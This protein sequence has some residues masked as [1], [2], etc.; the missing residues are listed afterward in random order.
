M[1]QT[2]RQPTSIGPYQLEAELGIGKTGTVYRAV[3]VGL[4]QPRALKV[5]HQHLTADQA[6]HARFEQW[7]RAQEQLAHP[8]V[9]RLLDGGEE[10]DL[11]Y[12]AFELLDHPLR[13]ELRRGSHQL[14]PLETAV[15]L[16]RQAADALVFAHA[17]GQ[18][19][20]NLKPENLLLTADGATL[21]V[22]DI[23]VVQVF[24]SSGATGDP[25][26][27]GT[28]AY[29]AP[30][31]LQGRLA[32]AGTDVFALGVILYE[33]TT[34]FL[35]FGRGLDEVIKRQRKEL[36][37]MRRLRPEVSPELEAIVLRCLQP[38]IKDRYVNVLELTEA[39][40]K[41]GTVSV[42]PEG[43]QERAA[44]DAH[45]IGMPCIIVK[46]LPGA[47]PV[48]L[49]GDM[50]VVGH[51]P[52][53]DLVLADPVISER[54][55][56]MFW[57]GDEARVRDVGVTGVTRISGRPLRHNTAMA[58]HSG[59]VLE[60]GS[61]RLELLLPIEEP[62]LEHSLV[63]AT[64]AMASPPPEVYVS[65]AVPSQVTVTPGVLCE[66]PLK[67]TNQSQLNQHVW[68]AVE[69]KLAEYMISSPQLQLLQGDEG[70]LRLYIEVP[71][72]PALVSDEYLTTLR[73]SCTSGAGPVC[74]TVVILKPFYQF[75]VGLLRRRMQAHHKT[76][77]KLRVFNSGN[78]VAEYTLS[79]KAPGQEIDDNCFHYVRE[80]V[81]VQ[82][83]RTADVDLL[84]TPPWRFYGRPQLVA[85][86]ATATPQAGAML[87]PRSDEGRL[88]HMPIVRLWMVIMV[89]AV[90]ALA[91]LAFL[92]F[93][94]F[95]QP[96][97]LRI[98]AVN[99]IDAGTPNATRPVVLAGTP[100]D[101]VWAVKP[102]RQT[103]LYLNTSQ[104]PVAT[105]ESDVGH[106]S[107]STANLTPGVYTV[108]LNTEDWF[109]MPTAETRL[110]F[111]VPLPTAIPQPTN[112]PATIVVTV[113]QVLQPTVKPAEEPS[114]IP[115]SVTPALPA[116]PA[117]TA[118]IPHC[119]P[120]E[121]YTFIFATS[122]KNEPV[123]VLLDSKPIAFA[124]TDW[125]GLY[126]VSVYITNE[127]WGVQHTA[128][129]VDTHGET[130]ASSTC[131]VPASTT[132]T[133]TPKAP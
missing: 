67:I 110:V 115:W 61:A 4:R 126:A 27:L 3:H 57:T 124:T 15:E 11:Y 111:E 14:L 49:T 8:N 81:I 73:I 129:L 85:F 80:T 92:W 122:Q 42:P 118:E 44:D 28:P 125:Q 20:L 30:E 35:P 34:G 94:Y 103:R 37:T 116:T 1:T 16:L 31:Q 119:K 130:L 68:V 95:R 71:A 18:L 56:E 21:H 69:G 43:R 76:T 74:T 36:P 86:T 102:A 40:H 89:L 22:A 38:A 121:R 87:A 98:A 12:A 117:P 100:V 17:Q 114:A 54:Q 62:P 66:L 108:T 24:D 64:P 128:L 99:A 6:F 32:Q 113:T 48:P 45:V 106:F 93:V 78:E 23:G 60:I 72:R 58:W 133:P 88:V 29:L 39:L 75:E 59:E 63:E 50:L 90:A 41:L 53:C 91:L 13:D 25:T 10:N 65:A 132:R 131:Q 123:R 96:P 19:H 83:G 2:E 120:G 70:E 5:F 47:L 77:Y 127:H 97:E 26:R 52:T 79:A 51:D 7:L 104:T 112:P 101:L 9:V 84:V 109:R 46:D 33:L 107:L 55:V 82:P 105:A